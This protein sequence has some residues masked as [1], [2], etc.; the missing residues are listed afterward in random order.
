MKTCPYFTKLDCDIF[1]A[2]GPQC[3]FITSVTI[4]VRIRKI[5]FA[6]ANLV[7]LDQRKPFNVLSSL[8][9]YSMCGPGQ[10]SDI[11]FGSESRLGWT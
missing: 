10:D 11:I 6:Q 8:I 9:C 2:G 7:C 1:D 5:T 4:A 3:H